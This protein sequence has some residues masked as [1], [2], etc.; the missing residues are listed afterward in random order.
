MEDNKNFIGS[1]TKYIC[2]S[3]W[4][5]RESER[6]RKKGQEKVG[7]GKKGGKE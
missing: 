6:G 4:S 2:M 3:E 5:G 1:N 7:E